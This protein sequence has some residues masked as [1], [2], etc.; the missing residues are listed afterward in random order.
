[1]RAL[2]TAALK[3]RTAVTPTLVSTERLARMNGTAAPSTPRDASLLPRLYRDVIWQAA[4]G[5][6]RADYAAPL[7]HAPPQ[8]SPNPPAPTRASPAPPM[9]RRCGR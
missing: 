8:S 7:S 1:M 5:T 4:R 6:A 2:V 9:S 3:N